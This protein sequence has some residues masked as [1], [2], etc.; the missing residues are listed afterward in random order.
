MV[1]SVRLSFWQAPLAPVAAAVTLGLIAD[2][3]LAVPLPWSLLLAVG[4]LVAWLA[5]ASGRQPLAALA[6]QWVSA[7]AV[8]AAYHHWHRA[9]VSADD[10]SAYATL[11]PRPVVLRG[12]LA[13]EP[14]RF[15][16]TRPDPLR[17]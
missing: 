3:G 8:G 15:G 1:D 13:E 10:I 14:R 17:T 11:E 6:C 4:G 2:R 5:L 7:A 16:T 9:A 12:T